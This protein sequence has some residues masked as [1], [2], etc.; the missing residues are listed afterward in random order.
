MKKTKIILLTLLGVLSFN[1][2]VNAQ[3]YDYTDD[4]YLAIGAIDNGSY[5]GYN[6]PNYQPG[7]VFE[8]GTHTWIDLNKLYNTPYRENTFFNGDLTF[9]T[10]FGGFGH[11]TN[12]G[13]G[14]SGGQIDDN[15][16]TFVATGTFGN[17]FLKFA[18][19]KIPGTP[20]LG[21]PL[22]GLTFFLNVMT[23]AFKEH[24]GSLNKI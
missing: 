12:P 6:A 3:M 8:Y 2:D 14:W 16:K 9:W 4:L 10:T 17:G 5:C 19:V 13:E 15:K 11:P 18:N 1:H 24:G 22:F 20:V 21:E 7:N 23:N